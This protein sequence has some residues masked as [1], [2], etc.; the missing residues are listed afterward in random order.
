MRPCASI[1]LL[2]FKHSSLKRH[3]HPCLPAG[4]RYCNKEGHN[5]LTCPHNPESKRY[6]ASLGP[7]PVAP[8]VIERAVAQSA[9]TKR[10][11]DRKQAR[12][13]GVSS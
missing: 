10:S 3:V 5:M 12:K 9:R 11:W 8:E 13:G 4:C 2:A 7:T 1:Q 6:D